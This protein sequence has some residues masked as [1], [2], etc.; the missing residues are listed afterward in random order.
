MRLPVGALHH[1][2]AI[3]PP[4][5]TNHPDV[6]RGMSRQP[7]SEAAQWVSEPRVHL[8]GQSLDR[9]WYF[10]DGESGR[11]RSG[12]VA[13]TRLRG[14]LGPTQDKHH[15]QIGFSSCIAVPTTGLCRSVSH[16]TPDRR[17]SVGTASVD[18]TEARN[19]ADFGPD[20]CVV[21]RGGS[22]S[23]RP[24]EARPWDRTVGLRPAPG[25]RYVPVLAN[26][27]ARAALA[28]FPN[29]IPVRG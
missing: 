13:R 28:S 20:D 21:R 26:L 4:A 23:R 16:R 10:A 5:L 29:S 2:A 14:R 27:T 18:Q 22:C 6:D 25:M 11:R 8:M 17:R 1:G 12:R 7:R 19:V 9:E 24:S 15:P 3:P